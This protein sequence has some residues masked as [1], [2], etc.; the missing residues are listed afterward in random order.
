MFTIS[1]DELSL[2]FI[3]TLILNVFWFADT[4][5][6]SCC[7]LAGCITRTDCSNDWFS[8]KFSIACSAAVHKWSLRRIEKRKIRMKF[9]TSAELISSVAVVDL[10]SLPD[11]TFHSNYTFSFSYRFSITSALLLL[12]LA[13]L[14]SL[15]SSRPDNKQI[16]AV[17]FEGMQSSFRFT[18]VCTLAVHDRALSVN[19][20][21]SSPS[22]T[23]GNRR[24]HRSII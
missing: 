21:P 23:L 11:V 20:P 22:D 19:H 16:P 5:H 2:V 9:H 7:L 8:D 4:H 10:L 15:L 14:L 6:A 12:F 18:S 17:V 13:S 3:Q 24:M 1:L